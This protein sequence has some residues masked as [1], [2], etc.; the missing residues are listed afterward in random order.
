MDAILYIYVI[1]I[2]VTGFKFALN[3]NKINKKINTQLIH[4]M[5]PAA[6]DI[7]Q[8]VVMVFVMVTPVLNTIHS[9]RYI[10]KCLFKS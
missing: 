10:N 9:V 7:V 6:L 3:M 2:L 8:A 4:A 5:P 1:S